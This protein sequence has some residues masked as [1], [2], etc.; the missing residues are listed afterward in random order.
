MDKVN[1]TSNT[2]AGHKLSYS[3]GID[4]KS[5]KPWEL[6]CVGLRVNESGLCWITFDDATA[7]EFLSFAQKAS[8]ARTKFK[9]NANALP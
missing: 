7:E 5:G 3:A 9:K 1:V 8:R 6:I 2:K 4:T